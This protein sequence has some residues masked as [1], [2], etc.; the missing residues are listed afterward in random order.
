[1]DQFFAKDFTGEPFILFGTA[2]LLGLSII[3]LCIFIMCL[4]RR[5]I[6]PRLDVI[7]R[8]SLA[9]GL[10]VVELSWHLWH[11]FTG[12]WT[13]MT[14]L[15]LHLCSIMVWL[16]AYM[17]VTKN[18]RIY[19]FAYLI[20]IAAAIQALLTPDAGIYG[21]PHFRFFQVLFSHGLLISSAIYMTVLNG[22][23]PTWSS[24]KRVF[25]GSNIYMAFVG[26]INWLVGSNYMFIAYKPVT[27]SLLDVL[28]P[29]PWYILYLEGL[30]LFFILL[31]YLPFA[32]RDLRLRPARSIV[33]D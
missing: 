23:R 28:P 21:F 25:I 12:Q 31:F 10:L 32:I 29:W 5:R 22:F 24:V 11:A 19:E 2:H 6:N 14:M 30:G 17:L 33:P 13:I 7:I 26:L 16:S 9:A 3:A 18:Y 27:A 15:P 1:M 20:G 4:L 8:N